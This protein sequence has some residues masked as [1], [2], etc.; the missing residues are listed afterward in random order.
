MTVISLPSATSTIASIGGYSTDLF[1]EFLP[2]IWIPISIAV[3][4]GALLFLTRN[5]RSLA[6]RVFG[7][8]RRRGRRR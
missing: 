8:G 1:A 7:G 4:G 6:R 2:V 3:V 5:G